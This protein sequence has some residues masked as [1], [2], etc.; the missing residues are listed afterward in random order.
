MRYSLFWVGVRRRLITDISGQRINLQG[1]RCPT[2]RSFLNILNRD[3]GTDTLPETSVTNLR[4]AITL[5]SEDLTYT[6]AKA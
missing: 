6:A 5:D 3:D 4:C 1:T 2:R